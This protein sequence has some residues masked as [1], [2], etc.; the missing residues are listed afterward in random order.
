MFMVLVSFSFHF[1]DFYRAGSVYCSVSAPVYV[2]FLHNFFF[3]PLVFFSFT[4]LFHLFFFSSLRA[5]NS[6][7]TS[8]KEK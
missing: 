1:R 3:S 6:A 8:Y 4:L 2:A 5:A 7:L